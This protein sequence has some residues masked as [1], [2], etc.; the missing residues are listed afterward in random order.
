MHIQDPEQRQ[1]IQDKIE[2]GY[3]KTTRDDLPLGLALEPLPGS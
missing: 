3:A 2:V 1:W